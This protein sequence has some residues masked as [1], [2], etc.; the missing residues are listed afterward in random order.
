MSITT[1]HRRRSLTEQAASALE[2]P[3]RKPRSR[4]RWLIGLAAL[5]LLWFL[6]SIVAHT[7]IIRWAID[8]TAADLNGRVTV[9]AVSL[10]WLSPIRAQGVCVIDEQRQQ[11]ME[12]PRAESDRTLAGLLFSRGRLGTFRLVEPKLAVVFQNGSSNIEQVL[13]AYFE[14]SD[15]STSEVDLALEIVDGSVTVTDVDRGRSWNVEKLQVALRVPGDNEPMALKASGMVAN[16]RQPGRFDVTLTIPLAGLPATDS[17]RKSLSES[18]DSDETPTEASAEAPSAAAIMLGL[19]SEA[20]PLALFEPLLGRISPGTRIGGILTAEVDV[21]L[22]GKAASKR[23]AT[24]K[25]L[26]RDFYLAMPAMG[27]DQIRLANVKLDCDASS[28]DT[29]LII[30]R[31]SIECDLGNAAIVGSIDL[32]EESL[33]AMPGS[34]AAQP[35]QL[36]GAVDLAQLA[37]MLPGTLQLRPEMKVT[38][39]Q[40]RFTLENQQGENGMTWQGQLV[41]SELKALDGT[42]EVAWEQPVSINF[43]AHETVDGPPAGELRCQSD[44]LK[45]HAVGTTRQFSADASFSLDRLAEQLGQFVDLGPLGLSGGGWSHFTWQQAPEG[46]F[47][48]EIELHVSKLNVAIP[49]RQPWREPELVL[50]AKGSGHTDFGT[51]TQVEMASVQVVAGAERLEARLVRPVLE[52]RD[53]GSW[54]VAIQI[55]GELANWPPRMALVGDLRDYPMAGRYDL[56]GQVTVSREAIHATETTLRVDA[57]DLTLP[58]VHVVEPQAQLELTG[59]WDHRAS[60]LTLAQTTLRTTS[61]AATTQDL[62]MTLAEGG[63]QLTGSVAYQGQ[64]R[65]MQR[66]IPDSAQASW[67]LDGRLTGTSRFECSG[68]KTHGVIEAE[69]EELQVTGAESRPFRDPRV[70]LAGRGSYDSATNAIVLDGLKLTSQTIAV[71]GHGGANMSGDAAVMQFSGRMEYDMR[72]LSSLLEPYVGAGVELVG[73]HSSPLAFAGPFDLQHA[74]GNA[75]L[76]WQQGGVYGFPIGPGELKARLLDGVLAADPLVVAVGQGQ[77]R[78]EPKLHLAPGP[79]T[80]TLEPGSQASQVQITPAMCASG[81]MYIAPILAGVTTAQGAFSVELDRCRVPV[82]NPYDGDV[83]GRLI[84][85]SVE[86]GPGPLIREMAILLQ[87]EAPAR[88]RRESVVPFRMSGGRVHHKDLE[89]IFPDVSIRTEGSVGLDQSLAI[90]VSL[91]VPPKWLTSDALR[92]AFEGQELRIPVNGTLSSPKLN[93]AELDAWNRRLLENAAQNVIRNQLDRGLDRLFRP[94]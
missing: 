61:L 32:G 27:S 82:D 76:A 37:A 90:V 69:I 85:H 71:D 94:R 23:R 92:L 44:F 62:A 73:R 93:Q 6:P 43:A 45:L 30:T 84:I 60:R 31:S 35:L 9:Q 36:E 33:A 79:M 68:G 46:S 74:Q 18:I 17:L 2:P 26:A 29:K 89:L 40:V 15:E 48:T 51:D 22:G 64:L 20:I 34:L 8:T 67:Q 91:P 52:L 53:G 70:Q 16:P 7:P 86:V 25:L 63:F 47:E 55:Q 66:W 28:Q 56:A 11:V 12:V 83:A 65:G 80:L 24:G 87:R 57:L 13:A 19:H 38:S 42:R 77:L 41:S 58:G 50:L 72:Q 3:A 88:L 59:V 39:G 21:T 49:N 1:T 54:P 10:G 4:R 75:A 14:P 5:L 81:L 78:L